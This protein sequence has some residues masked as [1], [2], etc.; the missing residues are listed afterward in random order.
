M[1]RRRSTART[2]VPTSLRGSTVPTVS[3]Y[4][5][6]HPG[7]R[8]GPVDLVGIAW[9]GYVDS[10]R[11]DRDPVALE[12]LLLELAARELGR[13]DDKRR[14]APR[15]RE[16]AIVEADAALGRRRGESAKRHVVHGDD[17]RAIADGRYGEARGVHDICG[18]A[19]PWPAEPVPQLVAGAAV[20]RPEVDPGDRG[21]DPPWA[22]AGRE[23]HG[24]DAEVG[25]AAQQRDLVA[26]DT[27]RHG[28]Q[29]LTGVYRDPHVRGSAIL[30]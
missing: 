1:R 29:Q 7:P 17:E 25:E 23:R 8:D 6:A 2:I 26:A 30:R 13:H 22:V 12:A 28:L 21:G 11:H 3:T 5:G 19:D 27:A 4:G 18:D 15:E 20:R 9:H 24:V 16:P 14:V 10:E